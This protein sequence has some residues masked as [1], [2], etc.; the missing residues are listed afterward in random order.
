MPSVE[1]LS[2][3]AVS[4]FFALANIPLLLIPPTTAEQRLW[5]T[6]GVQRLRRWLTRRRQ[7]TERSIVQRQKLVVSMNRRRGGAGMNGGTA[8]GQ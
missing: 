8:K 5:R 7:P 2:L 6:L 3:F 1:T 4:L